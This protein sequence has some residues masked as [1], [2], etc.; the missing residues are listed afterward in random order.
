MNLYFIISA[1]HYA[2]TGFPN[3]IMEIIDKLVPPKSKILWNMI[4]AKI[5]QAF[6]QK[7]KPL[8]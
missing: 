2:F 3:F 6:Y 5:M 8:L 7:D 1:Y 4:F